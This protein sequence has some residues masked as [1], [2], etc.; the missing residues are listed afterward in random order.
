MPNAEYLRRLLCI[1]VANEKTPTSIRSEIEQLQQ[2]I[3]ANHRE[4]ITDSLV[5]LRLLAKVEDS[6]LPGLTPEPAG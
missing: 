5:R 3:N 4:R 2:A 6:E 1:L